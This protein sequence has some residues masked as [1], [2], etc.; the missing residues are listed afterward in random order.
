MFLAD[1]GKFGEAEPLHREALEAC[2]RFLGNEH[3]NTLASIS[4]I[5]LFLNEFGK[6]AEA[7]PLYREALEAERRILGSDHPNTLNSISNMAFFLDNQGESAEAEPLYR[8]ALE[9]RRRI[10]GDDHP[11]TLASINNLALFLDDQG[12]SKEAEPLMRE[13]IQGSADRPELRNV[14]RNSTMRLANLLNRTRRSDES[15]EILGGYR[16]GSEPLTFK[17]LAE[18]YRQLGQRD[19]CVKLVDEFV[20]RSRKKNAESPKTLADA[21]RLSTRALNRMEEFSRAEPLARESLELATSV[22]VSGWELERIRSTFGVSLL[23]LGRLEE[24]CPLLE[25]SCEAIER[26]AANIPI[27]IRSETVEEAKAAVAKLKSTEP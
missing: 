22:Q 25:S 3:P 16:N 12:Q 17:E 7:E 23:G 20:E 6:S 4:N 2:R 21:L 1:Q 11:D 24:A 19:E 27:D 13:A 14:H 15:I 18:S 9:A 26:D 8:E 10:L 5:A